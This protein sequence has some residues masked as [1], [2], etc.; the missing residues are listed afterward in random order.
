[1]EFPKCNKGILTQIHEI[2]VGLDQINTWDMLDTSNYIKT[3]G[4]FKKIDV[5]YTIS[6]FGFLVD[7]FFN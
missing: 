6:E 1:M 2:E 7:R 3:L 4:Q 5:E